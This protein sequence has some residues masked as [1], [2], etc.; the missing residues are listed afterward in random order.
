[1][2]DLVNAVKWILLQF[3]RTDKNKKKLKVI[4]IL[5]FHWITTAVA[6]QTWGHLGNSYQD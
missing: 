5:H 6:L 3:Q 4:L 2:T 1:M